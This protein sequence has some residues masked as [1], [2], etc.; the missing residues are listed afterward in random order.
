MGRGAGTGDNRGQEPEWE[1][2]SKRTRRLFSLC[3]TLWPVS[4]C[5]IA[6]LLRFFSLVPGASA[7]L[8]SVGFRSLV[9]EPP[10]SPG[11][12]DVLPPP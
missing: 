10:T 12:L 6:S 8:V 1:G 5:T 11:V 9:N 4:D 3:F 7:F 2:K